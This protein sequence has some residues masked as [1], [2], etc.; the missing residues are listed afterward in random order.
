[1]KFLLLI[2]FFIIIFIFFKILFKDSVVNFDSCFDYKVKSFR[3][4]LS[5]NFVL[6]ILFKAFIKLG[7]KYFVISVGLFRVLLKVC[8]INNCRFSLFKILNNSL[9]RPAKVNI[10][11]NFNNFL[12]KVY[13]KL[14]DFSDYWFLGFDIENI[15]KI[16]VKM[17]LDLIKYCFRQ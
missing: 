6:N 5:C 1:M 4:V 17:K 14:K 3:S 11:K 13:K 8:Y 2:I 7:C 9:S 10:S 16:V 15:L 12:F